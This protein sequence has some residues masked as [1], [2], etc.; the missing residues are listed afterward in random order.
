M[1]PNEQNFF[2]NIPG[3]MPNGNFNPNMGMIPNNTIPSSSNNLLFALSK[4]V[5]KLER[6]VKILESRINRL[7][8]PYGKDNSY[9]NI[10]DNNMYM[11]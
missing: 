7:E 2:Y 6:H 10:P 1:N 11:M 5:E 3:D 9:N 8:N 4:R